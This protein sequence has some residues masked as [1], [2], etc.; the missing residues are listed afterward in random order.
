MSEPSEL[1]AAEIEALVEQL[2]DAEHASWARWMDYLFSKC[3]RLSDGRFAIPHGYARHWI[4]QTRM[5]YADLSEREKE[6]DREE[7]RHILPLIKAY[8]DA[9]VDAQAKQLAQ[10]RETLAELDRE[11]A[12]RCA[13][14]SNAQ[15]AQLATFR[16]NAQTSTGVVTR[17]AREIRELK[18]QLARV[19]EALEAMLFG[20][21]EPCRYDH[22]GFCQTHGVSKPCRVV[23]AR[24]A[25]AQRGGEAGDT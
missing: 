15:A 5:Q 10:L 9:E 3:E 14:D 2:A 4:R 17:Q 8:R 12:A 19:E 22:E 21:D 1:S 6:S 18:A 16:A 23:S 24:A 25:L 7:V 11:V 20:E 13:L